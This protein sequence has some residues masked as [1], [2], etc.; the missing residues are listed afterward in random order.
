MSSEQVAFVYAYCDNCGA[1]NRVK[2]RFK[3]QKSPFYDTEFVCEDCG[4]KNL[5]T[6][7]H[8]YDS[9]GYVIR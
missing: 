5:L 4:T 9:D 7:P 6:D 2:V 1:K 3:D 8:E